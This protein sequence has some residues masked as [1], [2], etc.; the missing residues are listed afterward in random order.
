LLKNNNNVYKQI[1]LGGVEDG[2]RLM[3]EAAVC[4]DVTH[5]FP[6]FAKL[7]RA[8]AEANGVYKTKFGFVGGIGWA[9]IVLRFLLICRD[10]IVDL[11]ATVPRDNVSNDNNAR[12]DENSST[13]ANNNHD[14]DERLEALFVRFIDWLD[15]NVCDRWSEPLA[16]PGSDEPRGAA[17]PIAVHTPTGV[18]VARHSTPATAHRLSSIVKQTKVSCIRS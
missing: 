6:R 18:F 14:N 13:T 10:S 7:V 4:S 12:S 2:R 5:I 9:V 8:W 3:A 11:I 1:A 17:P 16:L 15:A